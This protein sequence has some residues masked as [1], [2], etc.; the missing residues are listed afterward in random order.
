M[1]RT[2]NSVG[3]GLGTGGLRLAVWRTPQLMKLTELLTPS[4]IKVGIEGTEKEEVF[5]EM[6]Q[7]FVDNALIS[8]REA[9]VQA[10]LDREAKM[11]TGISR[12]L[13]LPHGK[14]DEAKGLLIAMGISRRGIEYQSLDG[15]PVY[16]VLSIFAEAGNPGPYIEALAEVSRLFS[17]AGFI[18]KV[19][20]A[21]SP[22]EVLAL[23]EAQE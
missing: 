22:E 14:L 7:L 13:A 21:G 8:N 10:L 1:A 16:V 15:Q 17:I 3:E 12:W 19:R 5:W 9:A 2:L 6:V 23:I 4:L 18:E 20:D 11:T